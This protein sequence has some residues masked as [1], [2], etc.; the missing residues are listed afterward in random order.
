MTGAI[1]ERFARKSSVSDGWSGQTELIWHPAEVET[2]YEQPRNSFCY[3]RKTFELAAMPVS[4]T[5]KIF[6]DSRYKLHVNGVYI[7]RGPCR[8]DPRMQYYDELDIS[9]YL[10]PGPNVIAVLAAHY[11]YGTGQSVSRIPAIA[12]EATVDFDDHLQVKV[13]SDSSWK[14][15]LAEAFNREAPRI[16]GCQGPIEIYDA[17]LAP[18]GWLET[19]FD[20]VSWIAAKGRG[21]QLSPFWNWAARDIPLLEESELAA[22]IIAGIGTMT[23]I[24]YPVSQ[25]H[26]QIHTEEQSIRMQVKDKERFDE[27]MFAALPEGEASVITFEFAE[28]EAGYLQ[29]EVTGC[30]GDV[31]DAV[32][33]EE[34]WEGKALI[35]LNSSRSIDRFILTEGHNVLETSF[36]WRACKYVQFRLRNHRGPVTFHRVGLRTRKY[37]LKR[38]AEMVCS[39]DRLSGIWDISARTLRLCMQDGFLDSSSREQQQWMGDGR[40]QAVINYHYSGDSRLHRKLLKQIGQSQD[41]MG[42]TKS[43][44][45]DG[46]HNFPPIPSF[47]LAWICSFKDHQTYSGDLELIQEWWPNVVLALR[48]FSAYENEYGLL[49]DVPYWSFTDWGERPDGPVPDDQRGGMITP[50]NLQYLEALQIACEFAGQL[51]DADAK[52]VYLEKIRTLKSSIPAL[53]WDESKGAYADCLV[54][55]ALSDSISE[56]TNALAI[57]H[58]HEEK[59]ERAIAIY[60]NVFEPE[61]RKNVTAGSPFFMLVICRALIKLGKAKRAL[62]LIQERYGVMLDAGSDTTWEIWEIFHQQKNGQVN[63]SSASHA[64]GASPIVFVFEGI[65][66]FQSIEPGHRRF[67]LS[68][69]PCGIEEIQ[70][71]LPVEAGEIKMKLY[72]TTTQQ[73]KLEL[74]IPQGY[75][76]TVYGEEFGAGSYIIDVPTKK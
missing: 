11:G 21:I 49:A 2:H 76:G 4:A 65:F 29:L 13:H 73:W 34:L 56:P 6:A 1:H 46:H 54:N 20:D 52:E 39:D 40:W 35:N 17:G 70:A 19:G 22:N 59:D 67:S 60:K 27:Y 48:W 36:A 68:P 33:A 37:P 53:L 74:G 38:T 3:F 72:H 31:I 14:C 57:L 69:D 9:A 8:S 64:W 32:H 5:I 47:C 43:R 61:A 18:G 28:T 12:A 55:G 41:W 26:K 7:G 30:Q 23:E 62:E 50:L 24:P 63:F 16:N 58:L 66:G 15:L 71:D 42:M 10:R 51:N 44:Y 25:L 45:P 75:V